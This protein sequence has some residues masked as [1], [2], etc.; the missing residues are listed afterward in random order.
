MAKTTLEI[1]VIV[2]E[3]GCFEVAPENKDTA[4]E[5]YN[6]T[7]GEDATLGKRFVKVSVSVP[8]P[9]PIEV[10]ATVPDDEGAEASAN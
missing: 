3:N 9:E 2:D 7:H 1:W 4:A 8:V 6:D 5:R 10:E